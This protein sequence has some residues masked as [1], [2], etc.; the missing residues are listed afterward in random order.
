MG[1]AEAVVMPHAGEAHEHQHQHEH[2][3]DHGNHGDSHHEHAS[4]MH[5][6]SSDDKCNLCSS[7]CASPSL[8]SASP[9]IEEPQLQTSLQFPDLCA[10]APTFLSDG[11]ER[12]PRTI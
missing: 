6:H 11:Q 1:H 4:G 10:P 5:G 9:A 7:L 2:H 8:P 3:P 12:P